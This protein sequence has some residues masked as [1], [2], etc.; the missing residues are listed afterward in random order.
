MLVE[1]LEAFERD[2]DAISSQGIGRK[3]LK[4]IERTEVSS[5]LA[6]FLASKNYLVLNLPIEFD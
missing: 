2:L 5:S 1:F 4:L 3:V 6:E